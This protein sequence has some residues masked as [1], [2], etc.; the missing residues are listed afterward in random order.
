MEAHETTYFETTNAITPIFDETYIMAFLLNQHLT[1]PSTHNVKHWLK[2][3][4]NQIIQF[5][6]EENLFGSTD[7]DQ[8]HKSIQYETLPWLIK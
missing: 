1:A 7:T 6:R 4:Y 5:T 3:K 2:R 8:V